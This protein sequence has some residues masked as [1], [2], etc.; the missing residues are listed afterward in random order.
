MKIISEKLKFILINLVIAILVICGI[1]I[2]VLNKL[3]DYTQHNQ[4]ITVP[5]LHGLTPE[6]AEL[7]AS[8][9][10][11]RTLVIDSIYDDDAKPGV[12]VEQYPAKET[13]VKENRLIHLTINA[14]SPETVAIPNLRNAA[15]RQTIQTLESRGFKIGQIEYIPSEFKNLVLQLKHNGQEIP[16]NSSLRK[17]ATIDIVLGDGG[18][19]NKL[20]MPLLLGKS[21]QE[22]ITLIRKFYLNIGQI[23]PDDSIKTEKNQSE[24]IVYQQIPEH[25]QSIDAGTPIDLYI[26]FDKEKISALD[27]LIH[28]K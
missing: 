12:I 26:T 28:T 4:F 21:L 19:Q 15:Y 23:V 14:N 27:T 17:G 1:T 20:D 3:Q 25:K 8:Q 10:R 2:F 5:A 13:Q 24:A 11:L 18:G 6:E 22:A 7:V 9:A 16:A